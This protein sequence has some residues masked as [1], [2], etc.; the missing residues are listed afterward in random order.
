M[1]LAL[2]EASSQAAR[3]LFLAGCMPLRRAL[4]STLVSSC[5]CGTRGRNAR[6]VQEL[7]RRSF[8]L[9]VRAPLSE[10]AALMDA[11]P[12]AA[13]ML[14][15]IADVSRAEPMVARMRKTVT[16]CERRHSRILVAFGVA[17]RALKL[18]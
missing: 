8:A 12:G 10:A 16:R 7:H 18:T 5:C 4:P 1:S 3:V 2:L 14:I 11:F 9:D 6:A 15:P 13:E 17:N